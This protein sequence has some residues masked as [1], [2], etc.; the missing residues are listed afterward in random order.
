VGLHYCTY[1]KRWWQSNL[2]GLSVSAASTAVALSCPG[3]GRL[4][5]LLR[6]YSKLSK[7]RLSALVTSTAAAGYVAG[8]PEQIDWAGLA[9]LSAGTMGAAACANSLNQAR[10]TSLWALLAR[11]ARILGLCIGNVIDSSWS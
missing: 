10:N 8:S 7:I 1:N 3:S 4:A 6:A 2:A 5:E 9:W 11:L